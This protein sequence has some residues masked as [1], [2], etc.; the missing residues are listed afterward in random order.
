M[1]TKEEIKKLAATRA[2]QLLQKDTTIGIGTGSTVY[3]FIQELAA[4]VKDG[5]NCRCVPTSNES[6]T[7][8]KTMGIP[9]VELNDVS[10]IN[11]TIDGADEIDP[12]LNVIKG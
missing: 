3:W 6:D 10:K 4:M 5:F 12:Q 11:I 2:V 1:L 8:A 9:M 7:M